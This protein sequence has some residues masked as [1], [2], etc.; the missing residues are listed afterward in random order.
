M[1]AVSTVCLD[2]QRLLDDRTVPTLEEALRYVN[3]ARSRLAVDAMWHRRTASVTL[4]HGRGHFRLPAGVVRVREVAYFRGGVRR[5]LTP[6]AEVRPS[7]HS[8]D[9]PTAYALSND[10]LL[11]D[12][13]N[14]DDAVQTSLVGAVTATAD[15]MTVA[16]AT[17]LPPSGHLLVDD[18][19]VSY[20]SL[21]GTTL[22][23]LRRGLEGTVAA[24]HDGGAVVVLRNL[25]VDYDG[26]PDDLPLD[27]IIETELV[28]Y[29]QAL[30]YYAAYRAKLRDMD[31]V[32]GFD[33]A[34]RRAQIYKAMYEEELGRVR[35]RTR[36]AGG[37]G[38]TVREV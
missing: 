3:E 36:T 37:V 19:V 35:Y 11:F 21:S 38:W 7:G 8:A 28:P 23:G 13:P 25:V 22:Y 15:T 6:V 9:G 33:G 26:V 1:V 14:M 29:R 24:P 20:M 5:V 31:D 34:V 32:N 2:V 17:D 10:L 27:G 12:R 18:E 30:V 4:P 16:A